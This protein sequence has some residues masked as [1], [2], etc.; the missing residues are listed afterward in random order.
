MTSSWGA[1]AESRTIQPEKTPPPA[2]P[3]KAPPGFRWHL[4]PVEGLPPRT[5][6]ELEAEHRRAVRRRICLA[7]GWAGGVTV[8]IL[9]LIAWVT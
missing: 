3:F 4:G 1:E 2:V 9:A 5:I 8:P 6:P 7:L